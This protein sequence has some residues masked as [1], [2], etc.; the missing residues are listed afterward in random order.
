MAR[1]QTVPGL[2]PG[3][4]ST[5]EMKLLLSSNF[6]YNLLAGEPPTESTSYQEYQL[7]LLL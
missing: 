6:L 7:L 5:N 4:F 2:N 1:I 3:H